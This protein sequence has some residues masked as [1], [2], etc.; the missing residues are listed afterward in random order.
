MKKPLKYY[1]EIT[2]E[3]IEATILEVTIIYLKLPQNISYT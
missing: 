2:P 3:S 1:H